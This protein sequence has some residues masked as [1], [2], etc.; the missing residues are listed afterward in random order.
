[1]PAITRR[2]ETDDVPIACSLSASQYRR[3]VKDTG[4]VARAA[5]RSRRPLPGGARLV[6]AND[7]GVAGRLEAFVAAESACCPFLTLRLDPG[8]DE[9]VLDITGPDD[10]R[11]IIAELFA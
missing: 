8:P 4:L 3:R 7:D 2:S 6:F 10:A 1:M 5:L 11:P 9:L